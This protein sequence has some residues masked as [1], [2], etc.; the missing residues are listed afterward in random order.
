[1]I[2]EIRENLLANY[3]NNSGRH[4]SGSDPVSDLYDAVI[5]KRPTYDPG[6]FN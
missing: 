6:L 2:G 3:A 5:D 4:G 1:M